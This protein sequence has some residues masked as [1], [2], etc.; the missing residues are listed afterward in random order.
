VASFKA[1]QLP[2]NAV[3]I[4]AVHQ[5]G[6]TTAR[7]TTI[8]TV[9]G[10]GD[11]LVEFHVVPVGKDLPEMTRVGM[12]MRVPAPLTNIE[13]YGRGPQES[14]ADRKTSAFVGVY[15]GKV[16]DQL[17]RYVSPQESGYHTDVRW[18]ALTN[19]Q[20]AGLIA[21]ATEQVC[22]SALPYTAEDLTEKAR[23]TMV[24]TDL[25]SRPFTEWYIDLGQMGIGGDDSWG[26]R[27][28][29]EYTL[30]AKEY[31]YRFWLHSLTPGTKVETRHVFPRLAQ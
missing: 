12:S 21:T 26:A 27:T 5:P 8:T 20:G 18:V 7:T 3:R 17:F 10:T 15:A 6:D 2:M 28:H 24:P 16:A 19:P 1:E 11:V 22:F 30:P 9:Y 13:W 4:T 25:V 23:G 31:T 14:Y 29:K